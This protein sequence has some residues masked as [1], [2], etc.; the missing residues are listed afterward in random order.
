MSETSRAVLD[1]ADIWLA[2]IEA[3]EIFG[4]TRSLEEELVEA[5]IN[6]AR[7][8]EVWRLAGGRESGYI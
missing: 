4:N 3:Q 7:A 2:A 5:E 6:L 8:V 1:A